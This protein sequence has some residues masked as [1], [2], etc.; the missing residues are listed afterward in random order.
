MVN[1]IESFFDPDPLLLNLLS[2]ASNFLVIFNSSVNCVIYVV[3]NK[4]FRD[5]FL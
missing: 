2:D 5:I 4:D 1:L 3:F